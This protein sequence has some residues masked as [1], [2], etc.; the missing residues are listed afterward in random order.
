MAC[1]RLLNLSFSAD[2]ILNNNVSLGYRK[3]N[4][5]YTAGEIAYHSSL[6]TGYYL[7]CT[8]MGTTSAGDIAPTINIGSMVTDG[9][10]VW[11]VMNLTS[12]FNGKFNIKLSEIITD[13]N[14]F[15]KPG[16][17]TLDPS[18]TNSPVSYG[19]LKHIDIVESQT[20]YNGAVQIVYG[21]SP[22]II[23]YRMNFHGTTS[24]WQSWQRL[25][26]AN[27]IVD[28]YNMGNNGY[29]KFGSLLGRLIIQW[30]T[31]CLPTQDSTNTIITFPISFSYWNHYAITVSS[32]GFSTV[33]VDN[34]YHNASDVK[35]KHSVVSSS[36]NVVFEWIAIGY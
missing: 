10:V 30:G 12:S 14:N 5:T 22:R 34:T 8:T 21:V 18:T 28:D 2:F 3:S 24:Q 4:T 9:T 17:Y 29:I 36:E 27:D 31:D 25:S 7:E 16:I 11:T 26:A 35:L 20:K 19:Y 15:R 1:N 13:C 33:T 23:Y 6:P 32:N